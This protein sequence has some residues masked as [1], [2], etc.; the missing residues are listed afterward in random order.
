MDASTL[1]VQMLGDFSICQGQSVAAGGERSRKPCLLLA[2]LIRERARPVPY[3]ELMELLWA[4]R[5]PGSGSLNALKGILHRARSFLDQLGGAGGRTLVL[6]RDGCCQWNPEIPLS[7]DAERFSRLCRAEEADPARR[8][9]LRLEGL[10][11]YRGRFLPSLSGHPWADGMAEDLHRLYL[12]T[13]LDALPA[14]AK[15]RRWQETAELAETALALEPC[16]E[17]LC[18]FR[19]EA[20]LRLERRQDAA[21]AYEAFQGQLMSSLGVLPSQSL[22]DLYREARR[23]RDP[24][25]FSPAT[26]LDKLREPPAA[27]SMLCDFDAFRTVCHSTARMAARNGEPVFLALLTAAPHREDA[28]LARHSLDR[29]MDHLEEI[30]LASLR[31]GDAAARCSA[32]QFVLLLPQADYRGSRAACARLIRSFTRRYPHAPA[33]VTYAVQPLPPNG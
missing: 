1:Y 10:S 14:L 32:D 33:R 12:E 15:E 18:C 7:V 25:S 11:L 31:R 8:L 19:M 21:A 3:G 27:G 17:E 20:L 26:L 13:L 23:D 6:S 2:Y 30:L 28:P 5:E 16:R 9:E 22:R 4:G 24:R 29:V